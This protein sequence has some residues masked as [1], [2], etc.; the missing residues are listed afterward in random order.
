MRHGDPGRVIDNQLYVL[1]N[2]VIIAK[3]WLNTGQTVIFEKH[4]PPTWTADRN[5]G[6]YM[7]EIKF[8]AWNIRLKEM[9]MIDDL[10]WFEENMCHHNG[11]NDYVIQQFTG[12]QDKNG[13]DIYEGD[14]IVSDHW[15]S[16]KHLL[17][18]WDKDSCKFYAS[19]P[20]GR[21]CIDMDWAG[22]LVVGN[23]FEGIC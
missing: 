20:S 8:R 5:E 16:D 23:I 15:N 7:R 4:G 14:L 13:V 9:E 12:M 3:K 1:Y 17:V 10:Y 19:L 21:D 11:D 22:K 6:W 2:G 18:Q